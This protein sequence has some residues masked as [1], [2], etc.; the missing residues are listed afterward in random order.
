M[1]PG[2]G[3]MVGSKVQSKQLKYFLN[4]PKAFF[5]DFRSLF[6]PNHFLGSC[7]SFYSFCLKRT[8]RKKFLPSDQFWC[9][10]NR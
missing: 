9:F 7:F 10:F 3:F 4:K 5:R 8:V 2:Q 1:R 6:L